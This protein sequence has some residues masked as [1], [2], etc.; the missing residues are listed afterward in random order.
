MNWYKK[1]PIQAQIVAG[2][3]ILL[4]AVATPIINHFLGK[5]GLPSAKVNANSSKGKEVSQNLDQPFLTINGLTEKPEMGEDARV[6]FRK[7]NRVRA[8][9]LEESGFSLE[10]VPVGVYGFID[11]ITFAART[12]NIFP[13]LP[14][15]LRRRSSPYLLEVHKLDSGSTYILGFVGSDTLL[16]IRR[17]DRTSPL[18]LTLYSDLWSSA[19]EAVALSISHIQDAEYRLVETDS[20]SIAALDMTFE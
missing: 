16:S 11:P 15:T 8:M 19:S 12:K 10:V 5:R 20:V 3:F 13:N 9:R 14:L 7:S 1:V 4:A 2:V 6:W 17:G 18:S